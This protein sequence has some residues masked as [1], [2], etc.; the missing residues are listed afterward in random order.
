MT[1][2]T[3]LTLYGRTKISYIGITFIHPRN[4]K[5]YVVH[6]LFCYICV[7]LQKVKLEI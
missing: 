2:N 4:Y 5:I 3:I 7:T 1:T 6:D